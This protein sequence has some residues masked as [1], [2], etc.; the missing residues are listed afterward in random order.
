MNSNSLL[1][2]FELGITSRWFMKIYT[3]N[4]DSINIGVWKYGDG[5]FKPRQTEEAIEEFDITI[6]NEKLTVYYN[7]SK[8]DVDYY[9]LRVN[10]L[11]HWTRDGNIKSHTQYTT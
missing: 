5:E 10:G 6:N 8:S 3:N 9:Y 11:W 2:S 4:G 1:S 7:K